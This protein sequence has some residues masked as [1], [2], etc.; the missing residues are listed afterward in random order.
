M[1][2]YFKIN[3]VFWSRFDVSTNKLLLKLYYMTKSNRPRWNWSENVQSWNCKIKADI[4]KDADH[5]MACI[6]AY[7][8][9][10]GLPYE[11][12]GHARGKFLG[13]QSGGDSSFCD[14]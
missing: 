7:S 12:D 10:G 11:T 14:P 9:G 1:F 6:V 5:S 2:V 8:R 13:D 3:I 4:R